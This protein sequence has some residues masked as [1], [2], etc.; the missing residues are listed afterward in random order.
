MRNVLIVG[1]GGL[2]RRLASYL[3]EHPELGRSVCGFVDDW[4]PLGNGVIGRI[5]ELA[6]LARAGF[7]DE[8]ILGENLAGAA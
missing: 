6:E 1:A 7:V 5:S 3:E 8:V 2:G 4:K